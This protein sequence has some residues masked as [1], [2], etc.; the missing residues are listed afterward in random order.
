MRRMTKYV[1][2]SPYTASEAVTESELQGFLLMSTNSISG[3]LVTMV[4]GKPLG[5]T[6]IVSTKAYSL[7]SETPPLFNND[8][9][10]PQLLTFSFP[11]SSRTPYYC[12]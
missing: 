4:G 10:G 7:G 6:A 5:I 12:K 1:I 11:D 2:R 9:E 8:Q 3:E